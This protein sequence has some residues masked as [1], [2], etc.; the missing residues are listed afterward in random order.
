MIDE[1]SLDE[2]RRERLS[3]EALLALI[4]RL[5]RVL[6]RLGIGVGKSHAI[7]DLLAL[8]PLYAR[9][10]LVLYVAPAWNILRERNALRDAASVPVA[11]KV[12]EPR[13]VERCGPYA[14]RWADLEKRS[15][16][17]Y[18]KA[19]LCAECRKTVTCDW[20]DQLREID[21]LQ[22]AFA[23]EQQLKLN[24]SLVPLLKFRT[25]AERV[26]VILD[27]AKFIDGS[28]EVKIGE[29]HL[30][31]FRDVLAALFEERPN[32]VAPWLEAV[33]EL[34]K[35]KP[36]KLGDLRLKLPQ[37]LLYATER[38]Q[39]VG[40]HRFGDRF[41]F[42][43]YEVALLQYARK[44]E[45][46]KRA[47]GSIVFT[48]R[49]YLGTYVLIAS[50]GLDAEYVAHR[51]GEGSIASPFSDTLVRHSRTR[52]INLRSRLGAQQYYAKNKK[53]IL[54]TF[55]VIVRRNVLAERTTLL[56]A[57]KNAKQECADYLHERLRG[58]GIEV[59]FVIDG[60]LP[61]TATPSVIPLIHYGILGVNNYAAYESALCITSYYVSSGTL[62]D[63]LTEHE[64]EAFGLDLRI[65]SHGT[66]VR[67]V[68]LVRRDLPDCDRT[69]LAN[70]YLRRLEVDPVIQAAGRVRFLTKPREVVFFQMADFSN[71]IGEVTEVETLVALRRVMGVPSAKEIDRDLLAGRL[72]AHRAEGLSVEAAAEKCG[73]SRRTAFRA[74]ADSAK[75]PS[76][77]SSCRGSGTVEA[78]GGG[79]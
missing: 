61:S 49:P 22:L 3:P 46:R 38:M 41:R 7:D 23:T 36:S 54:D 45:R 76:R 75:N 47:D 4:I 48:A 1:G 19:T 25:G 34:I 78:P 57:R 71:D 33:E 68:E 40:V 35:G 44:G 6:L 13:P 32:E 50:A 62:A 65:V 56:I 58:W 24:R 10:D 60:P 66:L 12:I 21:G 29:D 8:K 69:W 20:P 9:F 70:L 52:I 67:R 2:F 72:D 79:A 43:G 5:I 42:I 53:Q 73:V 37:S 27:E 55:A 30:R 16:A 14:A 31:Q 11:F 51:L 74:L 59:Q 26:L 17:A 64:P 39:R 15:C 63:A 28:F 77:V 18:A